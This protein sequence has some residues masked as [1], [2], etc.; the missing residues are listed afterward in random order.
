MIRKRYNRSPHQPDIEIKDD[1]MYLTAGIKSTKREPKEQPFHCRLS[2]DYPKQSEQKFEDKLK[3]RT[4]NRSPALE[5]LV[6][7]Q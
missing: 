2:Q 3:K 5:R 6:I 7:N 4:H 1:I